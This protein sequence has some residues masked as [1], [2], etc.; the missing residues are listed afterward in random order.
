MGKTPGPVYELQDLLGKDIGGQFY[1]EELSPVHVT[2]RSTY[3]IGKILKKMVRRGIL[4]YLVRWRGYN[5]DF[6]P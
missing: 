3:A 4:E 2:T 1:S 5:A 6:D